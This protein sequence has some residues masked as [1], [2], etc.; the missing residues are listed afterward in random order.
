MSPTAENDDYISNFNPRRETF[1]ASLRY[2]IDFKEQRGTSM[3]TGLRLTPHR[4]VIDASAFTTQEPDEEGWHSTS[5]TGV[6][7]RFLPPSPHNSKRRTSGPRATRG[8]DFPNGAGTIHLLTLW[9]L[10]RSESRQAHMKI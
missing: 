2:L 6:Y 10:W 8:T 5:I 4:R 3:R 7:D 9:D 1:L